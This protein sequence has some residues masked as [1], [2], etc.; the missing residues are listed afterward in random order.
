MMFF[1]GKNRTRKYD[2]ECSKWRF[3]FVNVVDSSLYHEMP[4]IINHVQ[5][6]NMN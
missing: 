5:K 3:P 1:E 4:K 6:Q 2:L